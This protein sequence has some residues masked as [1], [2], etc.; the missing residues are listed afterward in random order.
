MGENEA[1]RFTASKGTAQSPTLEAMARVIQQ[2]E[3]SYPAIVGIELVCSYSNPADQPS[4]NQDQAKAQ[5]YGAVHDP[6]PT[7]PATKILDAIE[8]LS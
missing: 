3:I 2:I 6:K 5:L 1:A 7:K 4:R 8:A